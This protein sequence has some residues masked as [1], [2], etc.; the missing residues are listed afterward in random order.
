MFCRISELLSRVYTPVCSSATFG[1]YVR[2]SCCWAVTH[3][4]ITWITVDRE[5]ICKCGHPKIQ[6]CDEAIKPEDYM[7]EVPTDAFGDI[8]FGGL[9][10]K[11]G[12]YVRVSSDTSCESLYQLM[13]EHWKLRSPNLLISVT[14]GAKNFYIKTH[15]KDK[16]RRGLIKVAQTTGAWILTGGTH[17]GVMKHVG[18]AVRDYTLSSGLME[19]QIVVIGVAPWGVIH[20]RHALVH[21]EVR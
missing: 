11:T 20:N 21:P 17:A 15:L 3:V 18:M 1:Q 7:G 6:H 10:Q 19:G 14:G 16:F 9:G 2:S 4:W 13:T 12:K 5:G 8:S